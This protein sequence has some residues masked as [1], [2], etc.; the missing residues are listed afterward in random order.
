MNLIEIVIESIPKKFLK[1]I[2][3]FKVEDIISSHFFDTYTNKDISYEEIRDFAQHFIVPGCGTI[4]LK[5]VNMGIVLENAMISVSCDGNLSDITIN[6]NEEQF[7]QWSLSEKHENFY[8][9]LKKMVEI[10]EIYEAD[11]ISFGYEPAEDCDMKLVE[12][13]PD[14]IKI[15]NKSLYENFW[16]K[17]FYYVAE[18]YVKN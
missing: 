18:N 11:K 13:V 3:A 10:E 5:K 2:L 1:K 12:I 8:K 7:S 6:F 9:L 17:E 16:N 15:Y 14:R 4:Y